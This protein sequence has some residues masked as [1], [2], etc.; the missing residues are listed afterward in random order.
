[1][2]SADTAHTADHDF[3]IKGLFL[4]DIL[5]HW[6]QQISLIKHWLLD[7]TDQRN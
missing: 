6:A 1:M 5:D 4:L 3:D 2:I 7:E